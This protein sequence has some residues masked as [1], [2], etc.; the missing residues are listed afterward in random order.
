MHE[1]RI[2]QC[3]TPAQIYD[4]PQTRFVANFIGTSN[5]LSGF[6]TDTRYEFTAV[7]LSGGSAL[8]I[9]AH[10]GV[11]PAE[12]VDVLV[13]PGA[14]RLRAQSTEPHTSSAGISRLDGKVGFS[15]NLGDKVSYEVELLNGAR[16]LVDAQRHAGEQTF[17]I[18]QPVDILIAA[19]D[20]RVLRGQ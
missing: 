15:T 4:E 18:G 10:Y 12:A 14:V 16:L 6:G 20:C 3:G 1:G 13:R 11:K 5:T 7:R 8:T 19:Q 2:E 17:A 9:P